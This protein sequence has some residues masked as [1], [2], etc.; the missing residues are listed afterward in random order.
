[1]TTGARSI[2]LAAR[3]CAPRVRRPCAQAQRP[4]RHTRATA[5]V[6]A[7]S[8]PSAP[9]TSVLWS[10][11]SRYPPSPRCPMRSCSTRS[12]TSARTSPH[13]AACS[14]PRQP[15]QRRGTTT[16]CGGRCVGAASASRASTT[17]SARHAPRTGTRRAHGP[18]SVRSRARPSCGAACAWWRT[19]PRVPASRSS[20]C[21]ASSSTEGAGVRCGRFHRLQ[22]GGRSR[23]RSRTPMGG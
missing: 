15:C 19:S 20:A 9:H 10:P 4:V 7:S 16:L 8:A 3:V 13:S 17:P 5:A 21:R 2:G 6:R 12:R 18:S 14:A 22:D 23:S 1:M 11:T